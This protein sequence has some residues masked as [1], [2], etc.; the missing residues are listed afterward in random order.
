MNLFLLAQ[1]AIVG[2]PVAAP[3]FTSISAQLFDAI[4]RGQWWVV[5]S[6][7]ISLLTWALRS[8]LF[9]R[10]P[11][12][13]GAFFLDHPVVGFATP[14]VL[15]AIGGVVTAAL[16]GTP[17]TAALLLGEIIKVG[18]GAVTAYIGFKKVQEAIVNGAVARGEVTSPSAAVAV[19]AGGPQPVDGLVAEA[20]K[21]LDA[22]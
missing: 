9:A 6:V 15:S 3:D 18:A 2:D 5:V 14:F 16:A 19:L 1:V 8:G 7:L 22:K 21:V 4:T 12:K 11:G 13:W 17:V 20:N 10:L